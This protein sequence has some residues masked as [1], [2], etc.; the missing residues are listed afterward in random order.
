MT[1]P[2]SDD[3][4]DELSRELG[5]EKSPPSAREPQPEFEDEILDSLAMDVD[6]TAEDGEYENDEGE[7]GEGDA[8][9]G[10]DVTPGGEQPDPGRKRRR[11]RRRRK[12]VAGAEGEAEVAAD[13]ETDEE[14]PRPIAPARGPIRPP[15]RQEPKYAEPKY[16]EP[17][18]AEAVYDS[19]PMDE[20]PAGFAPAMEEDTAGE[21]LRELIANWNVPSWDSIITGLNRSER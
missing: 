21:V 7:E 16:V 15:A 17:E 8:P 14:A 2:F 11:R 10:A 6:Q 9:D 18:Y 5:V 19:G 4:W 1:D 20:E 3:S 13:G 12:K